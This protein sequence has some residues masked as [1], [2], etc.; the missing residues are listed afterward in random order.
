MGKKGRHNIKKPKKIR[1][2]VGQAL[3]NN[4]KGGDKK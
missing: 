1:P 3:G 2:V 4:G